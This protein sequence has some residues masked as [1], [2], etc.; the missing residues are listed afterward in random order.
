MIEFSLS[1][2]H[3]CECGVLLVYSPEARGQWKV[4][5]QEDPTGPRSL[6]NLDRGARRHVRGRKCRCDC[7]RRYQGK[8]GPEIEAASAK[9]A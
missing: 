3:F 6:S 7:G 4:T 1:V 8:P 2:G 5:P 9:S